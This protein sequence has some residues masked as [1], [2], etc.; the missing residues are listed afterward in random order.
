MKKV[1]YSGVICWSALL[2]SLYSCKKQEFVSN[3]TPAASNDSIFNPSDSTWSGG[4][5]ADT[6]VWSNPG[7]NDTDSTGW[8]PGGNDIDSTGWNPAGNGT[9]TTGMIGN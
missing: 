3:A 6:T 4:N 7:G 1:V 5:G 2:F 9:D 8:N